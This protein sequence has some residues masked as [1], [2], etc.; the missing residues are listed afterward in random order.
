MG[1]TVYYKSILNEQL[2]PDEDKIVQAV[3]NKWNKR[4]ED[5]CEH[6]SLERNENGKILEGFSKVHHSI[7]PEEDFKKVLSALKEIE[8]KVPKI[9]FSIKDDYS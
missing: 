3:I 7:E 9:K 8:K 2:S 6:L 5:G 1:W 4:L